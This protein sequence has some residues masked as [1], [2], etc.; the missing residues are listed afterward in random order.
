MRI[1]KFISLLLPLIIFVSCTSQN[2]KIVVV[3]FGENKIYMEEF[4]K[5]YSK[6]SGGYEHAKDDSISA[7]KKFI[8]LYL[9]YK[10]KLRDASVRGYKADDDMKKELYDYKINIGKT[11]YL[12]QKLYEPNLKQ[13]Y[14]RRKTEYRVSHIFL[15]TDST[16]NEQQTI[17]F[18]NDLIKRIQRGENFAIISKLFSKDAYTKAAGGDVYYITAGQINIPAIENA[19]YKTE[20]GNIYPELVSSGFGYH[21]LK[22][23]ERIP[24]RESLNP[25]HILIT[26][27]DSTGTDSA[28]ALSKIQDIEKQLKAGADFGDL[29]AKYSA[30]KGS[31]AKKGDIGFF[32]RGQLVREFDEVVFKLNVGE[33]SPIVKTQFGYH[34]IK[35]VAVVPEKSFEEQ[36]TDLK[37]MYDRVRYKADLD[38]LVQKLKTEFNF[39]QSTP[40]FNKILAHSDTLKIG[41]AY[42][43]S[44]LKTQV[45][46]DEIFRIN[47][48]VF[49]CDSLFM[50][51]IKSG[52]NLNMAVNGKILQ[53]AINQYSSDLVIQEKALIFDKENSEFAKLLDD[54]ENGMYL[55][56]ILEEEVWSKISIDSTRTLAFWEETKN[57]Y[58]WKDR[59]EFKEI[60][61]PK[62]SLIN[63][64]YSQMLSGDSFDSLY[65]KYNQRSGYENKI[66][67]SGL[68]DVDLNELAKQANSL[69]KAGDVSKPFSFENGYSIVKLIKKESARIKTFDEAKAETASV[70]QEK[71]SK[72]LE[73]TY[74]NKLKNIYHPKIYYDELS[75]AFKQT[76]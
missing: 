33:V 14:D 12:Q 10:M 44:N 29:A 74:L 66:G 36:K 67:Y 35:L 8:D 34:L 3:E 50:N 1:A 61:N 63:K 24:R 76:N 73:D 30:D 9:N 16:M 64:Y 42:L 59:V 26:F 11:I 31:A 70:L 46:S 32:Q 2:S 38:D 45:G 72:R 71:E 60:Y 39:I 22:V 57:N 23:T 47:N 65:V 18:G 55:F 53:D 15:T 13:M 41:P 75:K 5:A 52:T 37:E 19:I 43:K 21:I 6:N 69:S 51:M 4:E 54:Y 25:Q 62:D 20:P 58:K 40:T 48:K 49:T 68:V 56:K 17:E 27:T 28:K 7:Y